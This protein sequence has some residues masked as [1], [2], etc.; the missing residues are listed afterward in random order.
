M[1][2]RINKYLATLG[3][4]SRRE[5]ERWISE[6]L[7]TVNGKVAQLGMLVDDQD[8]IKVNNKLVVTKTVSKVYLILNKPPKVI[9]AVKDDRNRVCVTHLINSKYKVYPVGRLDYDARGLILLTNDGDLAHCMMHPSF[10][11][12][13]VY[14]ALLSEELTVDD[15]TFLNSN[16]VKIDHQ[17]SLQKVFR[18]A[19]KLYE[20]EI[21]QGKYH[22]V[23]RLFE[24]VNK[25]VKELERVAYG[26]LTL[27]NL[28]LGKSRNLTK[29]ELEELKNLCIKK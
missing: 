6:G 10:E 8:H 26:N 12:K 27:E 23:K 25:K 17:Q 24:A 18:I 9:S 13:R 15:L 2:I 14:H 29:D 3:Y 11:V 4:A 5:I 21:S 16:Q 28:A 20:V 1:K 7:I 19:P 22:H